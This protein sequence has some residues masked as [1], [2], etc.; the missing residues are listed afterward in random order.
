MVGKKIGLP[1]GKGGLG[2]V[3][4]NTS[5]RSIINH[6]QTLQPKVVEFLRVVMSY[7]NISQVWF[8]YP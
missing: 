1:Y 2:L 5:V 8:S 3:L 7:L 4:E 6:R